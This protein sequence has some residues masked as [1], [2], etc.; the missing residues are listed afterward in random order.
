MYKTYVVGPHFHGSVASIFMHRGYKLVDKPNDADIVVLTGGAD[1]SNELYADVKHPSTW[2]SFERDKKEVNITKEAF[3]KGKMIAG[4][5][6]GAQLANVLSGGSMFQDVN[7][8]GSG[9][10]P[11]T[12]FN[13][14][15]EQ[16][17][18]IVSSLHHQMMRPTPKAFIWGVA[19]ES[20]YRDTGSDRRKPTDIE[21]DGLDVEL[22]YYPET[23]SYCFQG[24]PEFGPKP[25]TE[26]FFRGL[27]RAMKL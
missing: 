5:C 15:G 16:E 18:W 26:I 13:E 17:T 2:P 25:C 9:D 22:V 14:H 8:H 7:R 20:T 23:R 12:Y 4:I 3:A 10:H 1:I 24:H 19:D 21:K 6:R 11:M 27:E